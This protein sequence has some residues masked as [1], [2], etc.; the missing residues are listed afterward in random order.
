MR[1][2]RRTAAGVLFPIVV[3]VA[4]SCGHPT[5]A[6]TGRA[7]SGAASTG[8]SAQPPAAGS[9][10]G[11]ATPASAG[12][13]SSSA[14]GGTTTGSTAAV[15]SS[16]TSSS[17]A[18]AAATG[19]AAGPPTG[20]YA[21]ARTGSATTSGCSSGSQPDNGTTLLT[22]TAPASAQRREVTDERDSSGSGVVTTITEA[23][24]GEVVDLV[25]YEVQDYD[26]GG[27][28]SY[29]FDAPAHT[30]VLATHPAQGQ[31]WSFDLT[32][33]DG[34]ARL[35]GT[36]TVGHTGAAQRLGDGSTVTTDAVTLK[37]VLTT[38]VLGTKV[39]D[40]VTQQAAM[41]PGTLLPAR[42]AETSDASYGCVRLHST[43]T[44]VLRSATP[45]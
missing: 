6:A 23:F 44:E 29:I 21:L 33:T 4:A 10:S 22:V 30:Q 34:K 16:G 27:T 7:G 28:L 17:R 41:V 19:S 9:A 20:S 37:G 3:V 1:L 32:S 13:V 24:D 26:D 11:S 31:H 45:S 5:S 36:V 25:T 2:L 18:G 35:R 38:T 15:P 14:A 12:G 40:T 39:T 43:E 42:V 8:D